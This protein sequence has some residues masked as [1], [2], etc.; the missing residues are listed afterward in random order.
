LMLRG[1]ERAALT[2]N[3]VRAL[4]DGGFADLHHPEYWD[5]S[6]ADG[7]HHAAE[8]RRIVD[9]IRESISFVSAVTGIDAAI[10]K[11]VARF[12]LHEGLA[13][14]YEAAQTRTVP[15]R[16]GYYNLS[17][18]MPW[19]GMRTAQLDGAHVEFHRGIENPLGIKLGP[20]MTPEWLAE[21]LRVLDPERRPGRI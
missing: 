2:L 3:F 6:F 18:H 21:L 19:I 17:T 20:A 11:R 9:Q 12:T 10:L 4:A 7:A 1:Y 13:L 14:P 8:Y 5:I 16:P 15:R